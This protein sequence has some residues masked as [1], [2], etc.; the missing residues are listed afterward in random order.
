MTG[1]ATGLPALES[2]HA[3]KVDFRPAGSIKVVFAWL[4]RRERR[5]RDV[6]AMSVHTH[7]KEVDLASSSF[8]RSGR[9]RTRVNDRADVLAA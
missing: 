5:F 7:S 4:I 9:A 1:T 2:S 3:A 6:V 8:R